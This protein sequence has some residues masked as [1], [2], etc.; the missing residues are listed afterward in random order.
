MWRQSILFRVG[1]KLQRGRQ[2]LNIAANRR[3]P[4]V[5]QIFTEFFAEMR[6][7]TLLDLDIRDIRDLIDRSPEGSGFLVKDTPLLAEVELITGPGV[8]QFEQR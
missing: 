6:C 8:G 4:T 2:A 7:K 1:R 5:A 3:P